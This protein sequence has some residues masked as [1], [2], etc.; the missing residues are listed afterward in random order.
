MGVNGRV[1]EE[2][3]GHRKHGDGGVVG[4][5][6]EGGHV[7]AIRKADGPRFY[8]LKIGSETA[9]EAFPQ[10]VRLALTLPSVPKSATN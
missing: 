8:H 10:S 5:G 4:F 7:S 6:I 1:G 2:S 9:S 3:A